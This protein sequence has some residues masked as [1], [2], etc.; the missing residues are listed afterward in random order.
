MFKIVSQHEVCILK[1]KNVKVK[2]IFPPKGQFF[3]P[4]TYEFDEFPE[5]FTVP[6]MDFPKF[7]F[8]LQHT[9]P[10]EDA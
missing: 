10:R 9:P 8:L 5:G 1:Y 7:Q 6:C 4:N 2:A 3:Y